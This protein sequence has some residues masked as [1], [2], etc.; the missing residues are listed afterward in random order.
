MI[1]GNIIGIIMCSTANDFIIYSLGGYRNIGLVYF[2]IISLVLNI[3]SIALILNWKKA[4]FW[5]LCISY[6]LG[7]IISLS[8]GMIFFQAAFSTLVAFFIIFGVLHL[9]KNGIST[10]NYLNGK[11]SLQSKSS[12]TMIK[13]PYCANEIK[14]EAIICQ[15]C[16]K[17]IKKSIKCKTCGRFVDIGYSFCPY[18]GG[19]DLELE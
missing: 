16:G 8:A 5:G 18:C 17:D 2:S 19:K 14:K 7:F 10:W 1:I 12:N 6:I 11:E 15:Y 9:K 13:C 3:I 4:G